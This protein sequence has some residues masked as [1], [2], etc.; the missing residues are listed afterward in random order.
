[1]SKKATASDIKGVRRPQESVTVYRG[2]D[3]T[4][5]L[6]DL[7]DDLIAAQAEDRRNKGMLDYVPRAPKVAELI[8]KLEEQ[9]RSESITF[10]FEELGRKRW[11]D[12]MEDHPPTDEQNA[13]LSEST[14]KDDA[15]YRWNPETFPKAAL[16]ESCVKVVGLP[17][18]PHDGADEDLFQEV[19]DSWG[20]LAWEEVWGA[21]VRANTGVSEL[22]KSRNASSVRRS[23][24]PSL[25]PPSDSES[26]DPSS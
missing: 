10:T 26:P 13:E 20:E 3:V 12:L 21:C 5:Q 2:S 7:E 9:A 6:R 25:T 19:F 14:G 1:M 18:G 16:A 24:E 22:P 4:D 11:R 17:D 23:S 15:K 8:G